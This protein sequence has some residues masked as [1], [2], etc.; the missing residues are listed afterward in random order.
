MRRTGLFLIAFLVL[1]PA[2]FGQQKR[3]PSIFLSDISGVSNAHEKT[4]WYGGVGIAFNAF[5]TPRI[6][7]QVAAAV[8]QHHTYPYLVSPNGFIDPVI[9]LTIRT[10]PIDLA[11]QYHFLNET[12]WKPYLGLGARY[13]RAPKVDPGFLYRNHLNPEIVGGVEF[14]IRPSLGL[15][16][17]AKQLLGDRESYDPFLKVSVGL[18]WRF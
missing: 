11:A 4:H 5:V 12:R 3:E 16:L 13:V 6:S 15:T 8:E 10:Y 1:S 18:G 2:A 14:L 7:A 17:D 9:P